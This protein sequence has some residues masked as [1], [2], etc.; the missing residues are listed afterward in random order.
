MSWWQNVT[1]SGPTFSS[2]TCRVTALGTQVE[3]EVAV[4]GLRADLLTTLHERV[5]GN[6]QLAEQF[7]TGGDR[8]RARVRL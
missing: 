1:A 2:V 8:S 5:M 6:I 3:Q 4:D 7:A